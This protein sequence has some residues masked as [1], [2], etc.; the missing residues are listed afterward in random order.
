M[1]YLATVHDT[2]ELHRMRTLLRERGVPTYVGDASV[3]LLTR[4]KLFVC[5]DSQLD[6]ALKVLKDPT[7]R[8]AEPVD[9]QAFED[10]MGSSDLSL[11]TRYATWIMASAVAIV[12]LLWAV[13]R[14]VLE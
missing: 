12:L 9:A 10:A 8:V 3:R 11:L 5:I 7:H 6:D 14:Y 4:Q 13:R 1:R 2:H